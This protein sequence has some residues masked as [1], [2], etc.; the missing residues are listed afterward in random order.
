MAN[1]IRRSCCKR[2]GEVLHVSGKKKTSVNRSIGDR[3]RLRRSSG[4]SD[5]ASFFL[6]FLSFVCRNGLTND[7][8]AV[9]TGACAPW[10]Q[11]EADVWLSDRLLRQLAPS[12]RVFACSIFIMY[13]MNNRCRG[14]RW[15]IHR[16]THLSS[17]SES[18]D[19]FFERRIRFLNGRAAWFLLLEKRHW[20]FRRRN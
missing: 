12:P 13:R 4:C 15:R 1:R 10:I 20:E 8:S 6:F 19:T 17:P 11:N 3:C 16:S 7:V 9:T 14:G 18:S 2:S 5:A